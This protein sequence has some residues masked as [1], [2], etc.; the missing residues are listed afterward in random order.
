MFA[1]MLVYTSSRLIRYATWP[2]SYLL[3]FNPTYRLRVRVRRDY[4]FAWCSLQNSLLFDMQHENVLKKLN[5]DHLTPPLRVLGWVGV[6]GGEIF[7]T[8]LLHL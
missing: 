7:A 1:S 4:V 5:F 2:H 3:P 8:M 6:W